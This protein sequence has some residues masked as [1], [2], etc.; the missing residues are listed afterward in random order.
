MKMSNVL[1]RMEEKVAISWFKELL[2]YMFG[3]TTDN[4]KDPIT[5]I[6]ISAKIH[7]RHFLT[8]GWN[9]FQADS[10]CVE[11]VEL[12]QDQN[13]LSSCLL[14]KNLKFRIYKTIIL[15]VKLGL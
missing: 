9:C 13:L 4:H 6:C 15:P 1:E 3:G 7:T 10:P 12:F 5:K 11:V 14:S 2:R 8:T